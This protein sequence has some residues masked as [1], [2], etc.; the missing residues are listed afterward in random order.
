M[1][2]NY[3]E[4]RFE[5]T[6]GKNARKVVVKR[7]GRSLD[8]LLKQNRSC[9]G[10]NR[11]CVVTEEMLKKIVSVNT[12]IPSARNQQVLRFRLVTADSGAERLL[13]NVKMGAA[14]PELHLPFPGTEPQAFIIMCSMV[15]ENPMVFVDAGISAQSML[16]KAT[17]MGLNGL[18]I[19]AFNKNSVKE[20]FSLPYDPLL[21]IAIGKSAEKSVCVPIEPSDN[22]AY[23]RENGIHYVPKVKSEKLII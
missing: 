18:I 3:L 20:A 17:D 4:N 2:D 23:F 8:T 11:E 19:A 7:V 13:Q 14:L 15:A 12:L 5:E 22:H 9:R 1:A 10:Y 16:L 21:V 6:H